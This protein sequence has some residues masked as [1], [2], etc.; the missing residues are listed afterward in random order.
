MACVRM[1]AWPRQ[2]RKKVISISRCISLL[3]LQPAAELPIL[4]ALIKFVLLLSIPDNVLT[5][6]SIRNRLTALKKDRGEPIKPS[7]VNVLYQAVVKQGISP[8]SR[9]PSCTY[10]IISHETQ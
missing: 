7:D 2:F 8:L 10:P 4:E 9:T 5:T 6:C 1:P 3:R